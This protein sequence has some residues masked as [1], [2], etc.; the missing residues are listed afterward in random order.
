MIEF[1]QGALPDWVWLWE[2]DCETIGGLAA[3]FVRQTVQRYRGRVPLWH[4]VH[5]AA[6]G[7]IL[8]LTEEEQIRITARAVQVAHQ[9][10]PSAQLTVGIDRPWAEWMGSSHFQ[11]GPLHLCD[12]LLAGRSW[13]LGRGDRDRAGLFLARQLHARPVRVLEAARSLLALERS[14]PRL[15]GD[16]LGRRARPER[17]A[18]RCGSRRRSGRARPR[19]A[20]QATW[21]S[22]WIALAVAKPFVRT[23]SWL[24]A[25]DALPHLYPHARAAPRRSTRPS[26]CTPGCRCC[27][28]RRWCKGEERFCISRLISMPR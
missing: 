28:R 24:Q 10:D 23:V 5:R 8:G 25:S 22:K 19:E 20:T 18:H 9:A 11:L 17:R 15:D 6:S 1:R 7:E 12:Y 16:P 2:G 14:A 4:V 3:D 26:R 27:A 21:A 13:A